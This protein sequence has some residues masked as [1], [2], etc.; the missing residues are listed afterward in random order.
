MKNKK[1]YNIGLDIGVGSVGW[2]VTDE[3][4][5]ILKHQGKNMWGSR[6]FKEADTAKER[7]E[8]RSSKRRLY[9]RK[10]RIKFLQ[11]FI[12]DDM[13]K[14]YPNFFPM[15]KET[16]FDFEDKKISN[17][18]L[19][20]KYNLFSDKNITDVTYYENFPTIYHLRNYLIQT[21]KK[22]DIRLVY[23]ALHHII[24]YRGN[25]LYEGNFLQSNGEIDEELI[26]IIEFLKNNYNIIL[27]TNLEEIIKIL[28]DKSIS[29]SNKKDSLIAKFEFYKGD[30]PVITNII[31]AI[32]G[33]TFDLNKIFDLELENNKIKFSS[34]I[35]N[36]DE[37][38]E[39]LHE[40]NEIYEALNII[41]SWYIL[42]EILRGKQY[43]SEAFIEKYNK[44]AKD[45]KTLKDIYKKYF[46]N[47][48]NDM[49]RN[50]RKK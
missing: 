44:Y 30:K 12:L 6:I 32:L 20:K 48:Y 25:F 3:N 41:Y 8:Y 18:I 19:G 38:K 43:I 33:Y 31:N 35:E 17:E 11:S 45:L 9:R 50:K 16:K 10:E 49:F 46:P 13:E 24:K 37:I 26:K 47:E 39:T 34:D 1:I 27:K 15:L 42:Q 40:N 2:C 21:K 14:E 5:N 22:V 23:L 36:E 28:E 7:R 29:K 4:S